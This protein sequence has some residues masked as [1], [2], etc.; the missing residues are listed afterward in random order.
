MA[1]TG[2]RYLLEKERGF[3][4]GRTLISYHGK[5]FTMVPASVLS[6]LMRESF[7]RRAGVTDSRRRSIEQQVVTIR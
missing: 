7:L 5:L 3:G 1:K 6:R 2:E 4:P